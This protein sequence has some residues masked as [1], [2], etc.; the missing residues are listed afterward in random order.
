[1]NSQFTTILSVL[2]GERLVIAVVIGILGS[3]LVFYLFW[4]RLAC[5]SIERSILGLAHALHQAGGGWQS[6]NLAAKTAQYMQPAISVAWDETANR[7]IELNTVSGLR[8]AMLG[9]PRDIWNPTALLSRRINV[10]LAEAVPNLLVGI[11][12]LMTFFFLTI[13]ITE[14]MVPLKGAT[15]TVSKEAIDAATSGLLSAAGAKFLTSLAGLLASIGW[16]FSSKRRIALLGKAC[17]E[18]LKT[19]SSI[20]GTN[21]AELALKTQ[22]QQGDAAFAKSTAQVKILEKILVEADLALKN[23][24]QQGTA[25]FANSTTQ[26]QILEKLLVESEDTIDLTQKMTDLSVERQS[27]LEEIL[28]ETRQQTGTFKRFE[29]DLAVS[30]ASAINN[31]FAPKFEDMTQRL[32][33][34]IDGL[35]NQ[36]GSMN[37]DALKKMAED[38]AAMLQKMTDSELSDLKNSLERLAEKIT[39][40]GDRVMSG[41]KTA[42]DT[43]GKASIDLIASIDV[44]TSRLSEATSE[45]SDAAKV[46]DSSLHR[47]QQTVDQASESGQKG[48][49]FVDRTLT[50]GQKVLDQLDATSAAIKYAGVSLGDVSGRVADMIDSIEEVAS[51]QRAVITE[52][53]DATPLALQSIN[54]VVENLKSTV[55]ATEASMN[56]AKNAMNATAVTLGDTVSL[57]TSGITEYSQTVADL[58]QKMDSHFS[59]AVGSLGQQIESLEGGVEELSEVL[60]SRLPKGK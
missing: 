58:H 12:L 22:I 10:P 39:L 21:A 28:E 45:L 41:A 13:A 15:G 49:Q 60:G 7:V 30:L 42:G 25:A 24:T 5:I 55:T 16:T 32:I 37:Q 34:S 43:L 27:I 23:Q 6:A 51:A 8:H 29:T 56:G 9:Q 14:A 57:I 59:K 54:G 36:L 18:V 4:F 3:A 31:T 44:V 48:V 2:A 1:M 38:F 53:T 11:G 40:S 35:S 46:F 52:L 33:D 20:A 47:L 17:E 26:I 19:I 50:Q